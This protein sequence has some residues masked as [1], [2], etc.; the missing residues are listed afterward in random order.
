MGP[1]V[2][3]ARV[4]QGGM[5]E[6][7][8]GR[9]VK[10]EVPVAVKVITRRRSREE[11][12]RDAF[13]REIDAVARLDHPGIVTIH[14]FGVIPKETAAASGGRLSASSPYLVMEW[15]SGGSLDTHPPGDWPHLRA[16]L[17]A[18]L[19]ALAH[20]HARGVVHRDIKPGNVLFDSRTNRLKLIDFGLAAVSLE[21]SGSEAFTAG[22]PEYQAPERTSGGNRWQEGP[23]TD[24]YS[25][26]CLAFALASGSPPFHGN[27]REAV[28][29][30][31]LS[32]PIPTLQS[33]FPV[34]REFESWIRRLL[35]KEPS[36]RFLRS[37]DAAYSLTSISRDIDS[38]DIGGDCP[39]EPPPERHAPI[40]LST[41][42][43]MVERPK[44]E[45]EVQENPF[46]R[47]PSTVR[48]PIPVS[49]GELAPRVLPPFPST[50][51]TGA[52]TSRR[53]LADV[54]LSLFGMRPIPLVD[55]V[56]ERDQLWKALKRAVTEKVGNA[57]I[58]RSGAGQ[59]KSRLVEWIAER[60]HEVGA[61]RVLRAAHSPIPAPG[62]GVV[63]M[64]A[65]HFRC[66][67]VNQ[68]E[69]ERRLNVLLGDFA[70]THANDVHALASFLA[71]HRTRGQAK[72]YEDS[73]SRNDLFRR[74]LRYVSRERPL[75]LL[76][77]D[78]HWGADTLALVT[79]M[80]N[81]QWMEPFPVF[82]ALTARDEVLSQRPLERAMIQRLAERRDANY[83]PLEALGR[84]DHLQLIKELLRL[85]DA[86]AAQICERTLG[87]PLFANQLLSDW[88]RRGA[89]ISGPEGWTLPE[90]VHLN[91]PDD[92]HQVWKL[93]L[94]RWIADAA[95]RVAGVT[96]R[97]PNPD[98][99]RAAIELA[100]A[101]GLRIDREEWLSL[102]SRMAIDE[103][104]EILRS[105]LE[106]RLAHLTEDG[107]TFR[108][109][110]LRDS[111]ERQAREGGRWD[112]TNL[113]CALMLL[114]EA[115]EDLECVW[116]GWERIGRHLLAAEETEEA[117]EPLRKGA[118]R[119]I[120]LGDYAMGAALLA[121]RQNLIDGFEASTHLKERAE[122]HLLESLL[123]IQQG[124]R[125]GRAIDLAT[126][127]SSLA[128]ACQST[129]IEAEAAYLSGRAEL[130]RDHL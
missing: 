75:F 126:E 43:T 105:L 16:V 25:V 102:A 64:L 6:V 93:R 55:R 50:W 19:D 49:E 78:V 9:H 76:L 4:G 113:A 112:Q 46:A 36:E 24:L 110:L 91:I 100:A 70:A 79:H 15:L 97:A 41:L 98:G 5:G 12:F 17:L 52:R 57:L 129:R 125:L 92:L 37:A 95:E 104:G 81:S 127:A 32:E 60:A 23:W 123:L 94:E 121:N 39:Q 108:H 51:A 2:L 71:E 84:E 26:G 58:V 13:S 87:N 114:G 106:A 101:I 103:P 80:L 21:D 3:E 68:R 40:L 14:D 1:F 128:K 90:G 124:E 59:G 56:E 62:D 18:I 99:P 107:W 72:R 63:G 20:A 11:A 74:V 119:R 38:R 118:R 116:E 34:P 77:E 69:A 115:P 8:R 65:R 82:I 61:C 111:V 130:A 47:G 89:L 88:I 27:D 22:T 33:L 66:V 53:D 109:S 30:Q 117:L 96:G 67:G 31:H 7:W 120:N 45:T 83:L 48:T 122:Q 29:L 28:F 44:S 10:T 42:A 73:A 86:L 35:V 54:G 85:E